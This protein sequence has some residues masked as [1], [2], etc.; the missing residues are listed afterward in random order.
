MGMK[1]SS[2]YRR[3]DKLR[4]NYRVSSWRDIKLQTFSYLKLKAHLRRTL[5]LQ[6]IPRQLT[7]VHR[8]STSTTKT[9]HTKQPQ[10]RDTND[11]FS[12]ITWVNSRRKHRREIKDNI[13][14][15]QPPTQRHARPSQRSTNV[16]GT[17]STPRYRHQ[18]HTTLHNATT[19]SGPERR[20]A[21]APGQGRK[22]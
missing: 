18:H 7:H 14:H 21:A 6:P 16:S 15:S 12:P 11:L 5:T 2:A 4:N 17:L 10:T 20:F 22:G 9:T 13:P 19:A 1:S 8:Q 3:K